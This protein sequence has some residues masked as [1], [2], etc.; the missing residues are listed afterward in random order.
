MSGTGKGG[1]YRDHNYHELCKKPGIA[2]Q[3]GK[4]VAKLIQH[5]KVPFIWNVIVLGNV[6]SVNSI[7]VRDGDCDNYQTHRRDCGEEADTVQV[8]FAAIRMTNPDLIKDFDAISDQKS[9]KLLRLALDQ[10]VHHFTEF[11]NKKIGE[12]CG[13]DCD[14]ESKTFLKVFPKLGTIKEDVLNQQ[15]KQ[16]TDGYKGLIAMLLVNQTWSTEKDRHCDLYYLHKLREHVMTWSGYREKGAATKRKA[17][18]DSVEGRIDEALRH[19]P[20]ALDRTIDIPEVKAMISQKLEEYFSTPEP[21][22]KKRK[23]AKNGEP[24]KKKRKRNTNPVETSQLPVVGTVVQSGKEHTSADDVYD[25]L[26]KRL[27]IVNPETLKKI[28]VDIKKLFA[29]KSAETNATMA[30]LRATNAKLRST[31]AKLESDKASSKGSDNAS[32]K[33]SKNLFWGG[34]HVI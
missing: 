28:Q 21:E 23:P 29:K 7:A 34:R 16:N 30:E 27:S 14:V 5:L 19:A 18:I 17:M 22:T 11:T 8:L 2:Q 3:I 13:D 26:K 31:N 10:I 9:P 15:N 32:S 33:G 4:L 6:T 20:K 1:L 24:V 12:F 25:I